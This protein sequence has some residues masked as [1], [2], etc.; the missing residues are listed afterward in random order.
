VRVP[1]TAETKPVKA[2]PSVMPSTSTLM[3]LRIRLSKPIAAG[4][5]KHLGNQNTILESACYLPNIKSL[6]ESK[7]PQAWA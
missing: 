3:Y 7:I 4:S 6:C 2:H 1:G 5:A